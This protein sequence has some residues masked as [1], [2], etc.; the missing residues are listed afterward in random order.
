M[1]HIKYAASSAL[2]GGQ[3]KSNIECR[4]QNVEPQKQITASKFDIPYS[5]SDIIFVEIPFAP[6]ILCSRL[7]KNSFCGISN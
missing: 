5:T 4:T 1:R 2:A 7:G 3:P 6:G